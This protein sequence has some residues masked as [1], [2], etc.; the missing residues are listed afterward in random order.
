MM[1]HTT[2]RRTTKTL[3]I[4]L[5]MLIAIASALAGVIGITS[6]QSAAALTKNLI[7]RL[8]KG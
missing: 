3:A 1:N 8:V 7:T 6:V 4:T 2:T 5:G